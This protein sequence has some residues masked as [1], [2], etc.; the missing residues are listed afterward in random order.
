MAD[1]L[2]TFW[3]GLHIGVFTREAGRVRFVYDD[4]APEYPVSLSLPRLGG[5]TRRAPEVFL[6]NL[7][8]NNPRVRQLWSD[9]LQTPNTPFDLLGQ[10]GEDVAGALSFLPEGQTLERVSTP[11]EVASDDEIAARI[12]AIQRNPD[13]WLN[14]EQLGKARMSLAGAQGKFSLSRIGETWV[15]PTI[16]RPS[17]HILKPK[18][19]W[20]DETIS[21]EHG[22]Q[23]LASRI[24]LPAAKSSVLEF[25][26]QQAYV[27]ER[28]DRAEIDGALH[29]V[30]MEDVA[31]ALG[32][33]ADRKYEIRADQAIRLLWD[34]VST[35]SAYDFVR[36]LAYNTAIGNADAHGK[37]YSIFLGQ[38]MSLAPLY[39]AV[40]TTV[41]PELTDKR[42]AMPITGA[43]IAQAVQESHWAKLARRTGLD[44]DRILVIVREVATGVREQA[45]DAFQDAGVS[46]GMLE[47]LDVLFKK[48]TAKFGKPI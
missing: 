6:D 5:W 18:L 31:Q 25:R 30:H 17:T 35:D 39:D 23:L 45:H 28:F 12:A 15:W 33:S 48:T 10:V 46:A 43:T 27:T 37:N 22:G 41:W 4:D 3:D 32:I 14:R 19:S 40:P 44:E 2:E 13:M 24:G 36:L 16:S 20:L 1:A 29:R 47:R 34:R 21:L 11:V 8:P 9:S 7:L 26:S 38:S 42:L